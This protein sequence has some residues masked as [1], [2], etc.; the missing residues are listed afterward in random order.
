MVYD[1]RI[2]GYHNTI[3]RSRESLFGIHRSEPSNEKVQVG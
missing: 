2:M 1:R 3:Q